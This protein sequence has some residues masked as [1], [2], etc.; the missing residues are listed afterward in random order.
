MTNTQCTSWKKKQNIENT[1]QSDNFEMTFWK[2][3]NAGPLNMTLNMTF[4]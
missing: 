2:E 4:K 3:N 1:H